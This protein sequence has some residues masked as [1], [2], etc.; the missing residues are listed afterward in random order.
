MGVAAGRHITTDCDMAGACERSVKDVICKGAAGIVACPGREVEYVCG[1]LLEATDAIA[2]Q[3]FSIG[4]KHTSNQ[5][6]LVLI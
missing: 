6:V 3:N 2:I 4:R 1:N 5:Y